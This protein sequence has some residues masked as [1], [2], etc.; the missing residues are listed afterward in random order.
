MHWFSP[1][2]KTK[3][4]AKI[5]VKKKKENA[6]GK[7]VIEQTSLERENLDGRRAAAADCNAIALFE[8]LHFKVG[9][10]FGPGD[11]CEYLVRGAY[12]VR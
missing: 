5:A 12:I 1:E 3:L 11:F 8:V 7:K 2:N 10:F 4:I 6:K 9:S